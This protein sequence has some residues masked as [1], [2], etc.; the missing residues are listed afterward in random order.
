M[1]VGGP[2]GVGSEISNF[3]LK[4]VDEKKGKCCVGEISMPIFTGFSHDLEIDCSNLVTGKKVFKGNF[5]IS[6]NTPQGVFE[7]K[8]GRIYARV[9]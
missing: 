6:F 8:N 1:R 2:S 7:E 9:E 3:N 4:I 5:Q